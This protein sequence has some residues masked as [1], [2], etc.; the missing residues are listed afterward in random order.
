MAEVDVF[1]TTLPIKHLDCMEVVRCRSHQ[2]TLLCMVNSSQSF[3]KHFCE[4][5]H[6]NVVASFFAWMVADV[7]KPT[8][9]KTTNSKKDQRNDYVF[10]AHNGSA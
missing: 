5:L 6:D 1:K 3:K 2:P 10:V 8:N 4:T 9:S 7:L